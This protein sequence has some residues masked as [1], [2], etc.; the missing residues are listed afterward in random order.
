MSSTSH[1]GS[2]PLPPTTPLMQ[3]AATNAV[4]LTP[5]GLMT[6]DSLRLEKGYRDFG[7]DIDNSGTPLEAGLQFVVDYN[8]EELYRSRGAVAA[9]RSRRSRASSGSG[10]AR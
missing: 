10:P 7:V 5:F 6:L 9:A 8:K 1:C 2:T 4:S 3:F